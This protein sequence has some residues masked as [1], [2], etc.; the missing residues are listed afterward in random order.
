MRAKFKQIKNKIM[1]EEI[2]SKETLVNNKVI[3]LEQDDL[4]PFFIVT[5]YDND[6]KQITLVNYFPT[7]ES[8]ENKYQE[9]IDVENEKV[10]HQF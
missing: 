8:A 7:F 5:R 1:E 2:F 4:E 9:L 10:S 6:R 3:K